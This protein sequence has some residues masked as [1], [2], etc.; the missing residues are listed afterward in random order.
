[1]AKTTRDAVHD[2]SCNSEEHAGRAISPEMLRKVFDAIPE[3]T[4]VIDLCYR[5]QLANRA[6]LTLSGRGDV[7]S[8]CTT[9]Y[10]LSHHRQS[11]CE[12]KDSAAH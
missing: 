5:V 7:A 2:D 10:E 6:A 4:L 3:A 8:G 11:P 1:M 12:G 9:C